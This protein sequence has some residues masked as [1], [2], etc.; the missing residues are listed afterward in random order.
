MVFIMV[1]SLY[2]FIPTEYLKRSIY[3]ML[4]CFSLPFIF[5]L[6]RNS[7]IDSR[8]GELSYPIYLSHLLVIEIFNRFLTGYHIQAY[9]GV[10]LVIL[11]IL[12]SAVLVKLI[13]DPIEKIRQSRVAQRG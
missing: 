3:Y 12:V 5:Y 1:T 8:I 4:A 11:T 10:Q 2:Q 7:T 13:S 6:T 9:K